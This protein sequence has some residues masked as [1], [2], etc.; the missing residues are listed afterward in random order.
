MNAFEKG[1]IEGLT[2]RD[3]PVSASSTPTPTRPRSRGTATTGSRRVDNLEQTAGQAALVFLLASNTD[4][5][6][7]V[8]QPRLLPDIV[9]GVG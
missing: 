7:G 5:A 8:H 2:S 9:G 1:L 6:F 4:G 3:V